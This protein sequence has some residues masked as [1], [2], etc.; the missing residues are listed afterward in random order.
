MSC[1]SRGVVSS[2]CDETL[3]QLGSVFPQLSQQT[4]A[5]TRIQRQRQVP[6]SWIL[7]ITYILSWPEVVAG[8]RSSWKEVSFRSERSCCTFW[9]WSRT[10]CKW[11]FNVFPASSPPS[12]QDAVPSSSNPVCLLFTS[13]HVFLVMTIIL[14]CNCCYCLQ[15]IICIR[16]STS[17]CCANPLSISTLSLSSTNSST[18]QPL[19]YTYPLFPLS[20]HPF[21][22]TSFCLMLSFPIQYFS[23]THVLARHRALVHDGS[24]YCWTSWIVRLCNHAKALRPQTS[25]LLTRISLEQHSLWRT[26]RH[27]FVS[28]SLLMS[29]IVLCLFF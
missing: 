24:S 26:W 20:C 11:Q 14:C 28:S 8:S 2:V 13:S 23:T 4:S 25:P 17:S 18:A 16:F 15:P 5:Q 19:K 7:L 3:S 12:S 1:R 6:P 10:A 9:T 21:L 27:T 29:M 22:V